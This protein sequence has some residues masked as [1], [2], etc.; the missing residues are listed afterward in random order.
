MEDGHVNKR[1]KKET[2]AETWQRLYDSV[3]PE[4]KDTVK[5]LWIRSKE[6]A[7]A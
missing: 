6:L 2:E 5:G 1:A 7:E 4:C 3:P